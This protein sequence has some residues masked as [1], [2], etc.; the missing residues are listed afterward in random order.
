MRRKENAPV[1]KLSGRYFTPQA[2][3]DFVARWVIDQDADVETI[4]EPSVSDRSV[5]LV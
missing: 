4:L 3:A 5:I 1:E 2:I